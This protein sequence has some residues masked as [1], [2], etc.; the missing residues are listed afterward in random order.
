MIY[1]LFYTVKLL[2]QTFKIVKLKFNF[3][4]LWLYL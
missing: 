2:K 1:I 3:S 4:V